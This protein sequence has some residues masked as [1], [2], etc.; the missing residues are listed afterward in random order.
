[1]LG[2]GS[3]VVYGATAS[4]FVGI[5]DE[6]PGASAA[7]SLRRLSG[8]A[9]RAIRI[10][11][12][13]SDN[14]KDIGFDAEGNLDTAAITAFCGSN[15]GMVVKW[16]DQ[17]LGAN[18]GGNPIDA[19]AQNN[20]ASKQPIIYDASESTKIVQQYGRH[21]IDFSSHGL[22]TPD[23]ET[24]LS[25]PNTIFS[26]G[27]TTQANGA[28]AYDGNNGTQRHAWFDQS[29]WAGSSVSGGA[30]NGQGTALYN[31]TSSVQRLNGSQLTTGNVGTHDLGGVTIA[32]RFSFSNLGGR[33]LE[34][35]VYNSDKTSDFSGI[36]ANI[37]NYYT[38]P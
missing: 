35:I 37:D 5:L 9:T 22:Q 24:A 17:T 29:I 23:F 15:D 12:T 20:D 19:V 4:P 18:N 36:E 26:V 27:D 10:R 3:G 34:Y 28:Y 8:A 7:F 14:E 31:T 21:R 16:Y 25:Q 2:L 30:L 32:A 38:L 1:M 33:L 11:E 13:G 6:F